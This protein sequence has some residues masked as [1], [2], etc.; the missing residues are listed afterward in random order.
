[1][2]AGGEDFTIADGDVRIRITGLRKTLAAL[3]KAGADAESMREL[4]HAIGMTVVRAAG[5]PVLTGRTSS[6]LRAGRGKTKAVVRAGGARAPYAPVPHYGW[7][8]RNIAPNPWL[9]TA[10]QQTRSRVLAQLD[11]GLGD[12]LKKN[13]LI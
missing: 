4:M 7:P 12:L 10:L 5:P 2:A 8:A 3:S 11:R 6:T 9:A 1:M 13:D